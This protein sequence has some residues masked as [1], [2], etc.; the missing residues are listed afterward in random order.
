MSKIKEPDQNKCYQVSGATE[1]LIPSW[2]AYQNGT[3]AL[4]NRTQP[5]NSGI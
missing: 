3:A 2:L 5:L 4:H 1:M